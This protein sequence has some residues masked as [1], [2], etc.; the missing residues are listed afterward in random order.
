[1]IA[2]GPIPSR[3]LG[4]SLGV[5]HIPPKMCSYACVYCQVGHTLRM[6]M[7]PGPLYEPRAVANAVLRR[8]EQIQHLGEIIDYITFVPDGEP[9]LDINLGRE[10]ELLRILGIKIAVITNASLLW[11][12]DVRE[13]LSKADWVSLKMDTVRDETWHY[14]NRPHGRLRLGSILEG[15]LEFA[16]MYRGTLVTETMLV[17]GV[18]DDETNLRAV[19]E[20]LA[21]L[22][23]E[24]AYLSIPTR[25]PA[26]PWVRPAAEAAIHQAFLILA[27]AGNSVELL[28]GY[29]GSSI[30]YTGNIEVDLL[31][32]AA[33]HPLREEAV[34]ELLALANADW[35]VVDGL[36][37]RHKLFE[38]AYGNHRFFVSRPDDMCERS[39][40]A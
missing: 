6:Q 8:V 25:P 3:R 29:E 34:K 38:A 37:A 36:L 17:S 12:D 15:M 11:R 2:F 28:T 20:F 10:I 19:A 33:V 14:V 18:N 13:T 7:T 26:E 35:S 9:T 22:N 23:P 32:A 24:K 1:M 39:I 4:R 16:S 21:C 31:S 27:A 5:N 40:V 30:G